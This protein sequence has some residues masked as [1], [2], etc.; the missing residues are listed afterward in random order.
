MKR[1][2]LFFLVAGLLTACSPKTQSANSPYTLQITQVDTSR[3]P[4]VS[5]YVSVLDGNGE[6]AA[7]QTG[8]LRLLENGHEVKP[9][10]V[11]GNRE[12]EAVSTMLLIDTS[13]SM[14]YADKLEAAK[15]AAAEFITQTRASD[16]TG[17]LSFDTE[18]RELQ[19][20]TSEK[21]SLINA[22]SKLKAQGNTAFYDTLA[23]AIE[24]LNVISGRKAIIAMTDGMD[25]RSK[26]DAADVLSS[27]GFSGLS[28]ST[29]GFGV[30]PTAEQQVDEEKG[31]DE[32]TLKSIASDAGGQYAFAPDAASLASIYDHLL[33]ALQSEVKMTYRSN[34]T[35]RDGVQRALSIALADTW[36]VGGQTSG[37][38]NPGGLV[39][40][41]SSPAPWIWLLIP[42]AV[43]INLL[44]LPFI[45]ISLKGKQIPKRKKIRIKLKD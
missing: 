8:K 32:A 12:A 28:I 30:V 14:A 45:I 36:Q 24:Q 1:I 4:E 33:R 41:V 17:I 19:K 20:L 2:F 31:I 26:K 9:E 42:L 34:L 25:N 15:T 38:Y 40:E 13:G 35:L 29:I 10:S 44:A 21:S 37:T 3:F 7:I 43:L 22:L 6:P 16:A 27:I 23:K 11:S 5:V 39:P 18:V